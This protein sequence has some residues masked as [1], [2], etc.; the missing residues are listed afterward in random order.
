M[1]QNELNI[2]CAIISDLELFRLAAPLALRLRVWE[3]VSYF[4]FCVAY[5]KCNLHYVGGISLV[6]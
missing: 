1:K 4:F 3:W 2:V 5:T 6:P